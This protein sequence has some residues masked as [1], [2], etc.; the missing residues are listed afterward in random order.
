VSGRPDTV[1]NRAGSVRPDQDRAH[2]G[3]HTAPRAPSTAP[4]SRTPPSD[5]TRKEAAMVRLLTNLRFWILACALAWLTTV[6][7]LIAHGA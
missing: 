4:V 2:L 7:V 5:S 3:A 1:P 6:T